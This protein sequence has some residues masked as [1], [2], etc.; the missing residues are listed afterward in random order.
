MRKSYS[1]LVMMAFIF[2]GLLA[3]A[4]LFAAEPLPSH[5]KAVTI[6]SDQALIKREGIVAVG[7]GTR[8]LT[9]EVEA[10]RVD[11][12]SVSGKV[13]GEGE[14]VSVQVREIPLKEA[15]Q[16][17]VKT[18]E[19]KI[20]AFKKTIK[21]AAEEKEVLN[22]K[23]TFLKSVIACS[24][25]EAPREMKAGLPKATEL[26]KTLK[27]LT[28]S[29]SA[30]NAQRQ[31]LNT[32]IEDADRDIKALEK[33]MAFFK[34]PKGE[35]SRKLIEVVFNSA[36]PQKIKVQ[37]EYLVKN[38]SWS[39]LYR[40]S[41]PE[42]MDGIDLAMFSSI[43][44]KT[45]EDWHRVALAVSNAVPVTGVALPSPPSWNIDIQKP[46]PNT[47]AGKSGDSASSGTAADAA[48]KTEAP[49]T[50][51]TKPERPKADNLPLI[52]SAPEKREPTSSAVQ[53]EVSAM[54]FEHQ[55]PQ[56][57]SI[58]SLDKET[59]LPLHAKKLQGDFFYY[60]VPRISPFTFLI[61]ATRAEHEL[62]SGPINVFYGERFVGKTVLG[63]KKAGEEV[64]FNLGADS[65]VKI[66]REMV[67]DKSG[68]AG[69]SGSTIVREIAYKM[70]AENTRDK[71][72]RLKL[73]DTIPV[74]KNDRVEVKDVKVS[75]DPSAK[76]YE[77]KEGVLMWEAELKPEEK[78]EITVE[79]VISYPKDTP[80][81]G[82]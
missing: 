62:L 29:F 59:V 42:Q 47:D 76:N 28:A 38:A 79:F 6:Y 67:K 19:K 18:L 41:V 25:K 54:S 13:F 70:T 5:I 68:E 21:T 60:A 74:A 50:E 15:P 75:P 24:E 16:D 39:P 26:E 64:F 48:P 9:F 10:F 65:A 56:V 63:D 27:F 73:L 57:M 3:A 43:R 58:D 78:K 7:K 30:I 45:G 52:G 66:S 53:R 17:S 20:K 81:T 72:V 51:A 34:G 36:K 1:G 8:E 14:L 77:G 2:T 49:K 22:K 31:A 71:A 55:M 44:Q 69:F 11:N 40:V 12:D 80:V 37:M 4:P 82:L 35:F 33:E 61:C 23:E 32:K 46:E